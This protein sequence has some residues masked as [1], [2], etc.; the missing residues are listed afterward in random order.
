MSFNPT[1]RIAL[2]KTGSYGRPGSYA[3]RF[4][5]PDPLTGARRRKT[6]GGLTKPRATQLLAELIAEHQLGTAGTDGNFRVADGWALYL[7]ELEQRVEA[8]T[9]KYNTLS[10]YKRAWRLYL[11]PWW[12]DRRMA[13]VRP[14]DIGRL[15]SRHLASGL[16]PNGMTVAWSVARCCFDRAVRNG[17]TGSSPFARIKKG[18]ILTQTAP[19]AGRVKCWTP[20]QVQQFRA[21]AR[22]AEH[23]D[24]W[25][26]ELIIFT[27][28]RR[29][30]ALGLCDDAVDLGEAAPAL[31][32]IR[33]WT[34]GQGRPPFWEAPKTR[35]SVRTVA[36][37]AEAVKA[38]EEQRFVRA[39][40]EL[41]GTG[42]W[43]NEAGAVFV[44]PDGSCPN[45]DS[46]SNRF[47]TFIDSVGLP[48]IGLHGLRHTFATLA[49]DAQLPTKVVS[50]IL[51]HASTAITADIYQHTSPELHHRAAEAVA[52]VLSRLEVS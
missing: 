30:E 16:A 33:Q 9:L 5:Y 38:L 4:Q 31:R 47:R 52:L 11:E 45:P 39:A 20:E 25:L 34:K 21:A 17:Y 43:L 36:L 44:G 19:G 37:C 41:S 10:I 22:Q 26:W 51:G 32:V 8:G 29:G 6:R 2:D 7:E 24:R 35:C 27:G 3:L 28:L 13:E 50:D 23:R 42:R 40:H 1:G 48:R 49:L 12:A 14:A 46:W 18:E 15:F